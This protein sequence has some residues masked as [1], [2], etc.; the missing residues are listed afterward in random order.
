MSSHPVAFLPPT[1]PM[2]ASELRRG[3]YVLFATNGSDR[4]GDDDSQPP[5]VLGVTH[6]TRV[7]RP[8]GDIVTGA[9]ALAITTEGATIA[10]PDGLPFSWV[11]LPAATYAVY[12]PT[13]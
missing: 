11:E 13:S 7:D 10:G 2:R 9:G 1:V 8:R 12:R 3:D 4:P 5:N 6:V